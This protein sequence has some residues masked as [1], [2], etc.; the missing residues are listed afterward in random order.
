M[1]PGLEHARVEAGSKP[2][3]IRTELGN[4]SYAF[5]LSVVMVGRND[6]KRGDYV[7]RLQNSLDFFIAQ[8]EYYNVNIEIIVVEWNPFRGMSRL[9]HLLR[10]DPTSKIPV[11]IITVS[12]QLFLQS[13]A[14]V[15]QQ[16]CCV[17]YFLLVFPFARISSFCKEIEFSCRTKVGQPEQLSAQSQLNCS[18]KFNR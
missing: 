16:Q 5:Y 4:Q 1:S 14:I 7:G 11:R 13:K 2:S 15:L 17:S 12:E 6:D 3:D 18:V 8:A 9:H 10:T